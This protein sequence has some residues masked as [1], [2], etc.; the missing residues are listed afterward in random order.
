V[1]QS[2]QII[3]DYTLY[4]F[5]PISNRLSLDYT[6]R[7]LL[8]AVLTPRLT[9]GLIHSARYQPS[10]DYLFEGDGQQ[11][12]SQADQA[13][14]FTLGAT[15]T[16]SPSPILSVTLSPEYQA[17]DRSQ[18]LDGE[19]APQR[20]SRT[21]NFSGGANVN[22]PVGARGRLTGTLRRTYR[23]DRSTTFPSGV[24]T[25]SPRGEVD[26]WNGSLTFSWEL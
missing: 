22:V 25:P 24:P 7:T 5:T 14:N 13:E 15:M 1:N 12:F 8:N 23:A 19:E 11:Y 20:R 2:N 16:Y 10:G 26:Y 18:T 4:T 21:L 17:A 3:A 9:I 6:S